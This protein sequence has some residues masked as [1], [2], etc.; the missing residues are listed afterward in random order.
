M[1]AAD[2][3]PM[4]MMEVELDPVDFNIDDDGKVPPIPT[5]FICNEPTTTE[6]EEGHKLLFQSPS[7]PAAT[8]LYQLLNITPTDNNNRFPIENE[9]ELCC[10]TCNQI[11]HR[12]AEI[13][14]QLNQLNEELQSYK[15]TIQQDLDQ[16]FQQ[17]V[18]SL[19]HAENE[20][21]DQIDLI[22]ARKQL[23]RFLLQSTSKS[24]LL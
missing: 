18:D 16:S 6:E 4:A 1:E 5:C 15:Q 11:L 21:Q 14:K 22:K 13:Y 7:S 20:D 10:S 24:I 12:A 9:E 3:E 8:A 2:P 19:K 23:Q 17:N